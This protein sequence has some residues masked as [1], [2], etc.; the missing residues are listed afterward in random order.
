KNGYHNLA[1]LSSCAFVDGFYY[2]P[3]IDKEL[4]LQYKEDLIV[5]TGNTYG[6]VPSLILNVGEKQAEEALVWYHEQFGE[7]FYVE[8]LNHE[9]EEE[10]VVNDTLLKFARKYGVKYFAS[11]NVY[12]L[13]KEDA[14]AHDIL[15][16]VKEGEFQS[17]PKGRGRGYRFGFPNEEFYFK[18]TEAMKELFKDTPEAILTTLELADKIESYTLA[19]DVLLPAFDIPEQCADPQDEVDGG[20]RGE[21]AELRHLTYEGAKKRYGEI[22]EEI[23][24]RLDFE[25]ETIANTG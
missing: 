22:T 23:K 9:L 2:V 11:N 18:D 1:K 21:N 4:I 14:N 16:C 7:D 3:R 20:K 12:Y 15:L 17:T 19:R 10:K 13:G 6:E 8:L 24:Q 5:T 25:L